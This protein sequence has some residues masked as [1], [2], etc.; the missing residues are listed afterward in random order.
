MKKAYNIAFFGLIVF[1]LFLS[2]WER[3]EDSKTKGNTV[4]HWFDIYWE[5]RVEANYWNNKYNGIP[6][7]T[8][9]I[10]IGDKIYKYPK[11]K[12]PIF[13]YYHDDTTTINTEK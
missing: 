7:D 12:Y 8:A 5:V 10:S 6:I 13:L 4:N 9:R 11:G 3:V 2:L 1:L